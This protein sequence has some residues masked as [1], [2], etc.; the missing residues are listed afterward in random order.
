MIKR[1]LLPLDPSEYSK[2]ALDYACNLAKRH[3]ASITGLVVLDIPGIEKSIGPVPIGGFHYAEKL[4]KEKAKQAHKRIDSLLEAFEKRCRDENILFEKSE[5]QGVPAKN[6]ILESIFYDIVVMGLRTFFHFE[7]DNEPGDSLDK[8]LDH[9]VTPIIAV[10]ETPV[11]FNENEKTKT[12]L[13]F[14]NTL[15]SARALQKFAQLACKANYD[16]TILMSN[17]EMELAEFALNEAKQYLEAH[18]FKD[19]KTKWTSQDIVN[20]FEE[21]YYEEAEFFVLGAHSKSGLINFNVGK[22]NKFLIKEGQKP[23]MIAQ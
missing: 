9:S 16:L 10:P 13:A 14:N 8:V 5:R 7:T 19:V 6:I 23:I 2:S 3:G 12:I 21:K 22:L 4:E 17:K 1:I 11:V 15:P 18:G 20:A